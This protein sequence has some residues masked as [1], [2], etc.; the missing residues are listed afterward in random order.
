[1]NALHKIALKITERGRLM[2]WK[3]GTKTA[4]NLNLEAWVG[5]WAALE[6][7]GHPEAGHVGGYVSM[8]IVARG[9]RETLRIAESA[10]AEAAA[11]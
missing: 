10:K 4:D 5:A 1:M 3:P 6:A 9:Y 11:A 2:R 7:V 8:V